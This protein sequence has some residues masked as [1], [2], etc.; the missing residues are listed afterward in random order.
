MM[1]HT[2]DIRAR[3]GHAGRLQAHGH[4]GF[5][6]LEI[7]IA[8]AALG[9]IAV[10][11][12]SIFDATGK[13][14]AA[15]KRV[16][17]FNAYASLIEQQ[18]R[19][20]ISSIAP[21]SFIVVRN[22]YASAEGGDSIN[23]NPPVGN[24]DAV[25]LFDGDER[26]R[27]RRIDS[28]QFFAKGQFQSVRAALHPEYTAA[29]DSARIY[30]GHG[31]RGRQPVAFNPTNPYYRPELDGNLWNNQTIDAAAR[32]G[33]DNPN[34]DPPN[35]N[36]FASEWI[37]LRHVTLLAPPRSSQTLPSS[38]VFGFAPTNAAL[39]DS[40]IQISLQPAAS[41]LFRRLAGIFPA[42][43]VPAALRP[44]ARAF[45]SGLVDIA[46]T[47]LS[48][49]RTV[50]TTASVFPQGANVRFYVPNSNVSPDEQNNAGADGQYR[51]FGQS[52][53]QDP[54]VIARMQA[55]MD[56]SLPANLTAQQG[57]QRQRIRCELSPRNFVG[58][59]DRN[60]WAS[61]LEAAYRAA[62]QVMLSASN[63]LPR[64]TE[65]IV[66]WSFGNSFPSAPG[67]PGYVA[68]RAG[69]L[70]WHGMERRVNANVVASPYD[71]T[72]VVQQHRT[73][74]RTISGVQA[75][76]LT[77][78]RLIHGDQY[79]SAFPTPGVPLMSY[80]GYYN[81]MFDPDVDNDG[82]LESPGDSASPTIPWAWPKLIRV[83]LSLADPADP[84]VER[85]FQ[86]IFDV[87]E[88]GI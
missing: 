53:P 34:V 6:L 47:D 68:G 87:P 67:S 74:F 22:E 52:Q 44:G 18:I 58:S 14:L 76:F 31:Q 78:T 66:E 26:P 49:V 21:D 29:S 11:V 81:P 64:C 43:P 85:T 40:Q 75:T 88:R 56:D 45:S 2:K 20:D 13:T 60:Q 59:L 36:R 86:F 57:A 48:R 33:L 25:A 4:R 65:F 37:L 82:K 5:T 10:G 23:P 30:Y 19:S 1:N 51:I 61:D 79:A 84:S 39:R 71:S 55:W 42:A 32:L 62:D 72:S 83:T 15:G 12:A 77:A 46:A 8:V 16:S 7:L 28:L 69:E 17:A 54:D 50:I 73:R 41:D 63:F 24:P 35:P 27:L 70:I 38:P 80:F 3:A 9:L